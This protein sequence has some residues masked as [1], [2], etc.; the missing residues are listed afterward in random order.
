MTI[1]GFVKANSMNY[2][3]GRTGGI[4]FLVIHYTANDGDKAKS[5][6]NFFANN[7]P[8]SSAHYFVDENE[9]WQ[10]IEDK[11]TAW[12][13]GQGGMPSIVHPDCR[14]NNSIGIEMCSRKNADKTYYIKPEVVERTVHLTAMLAKKHKISLEN[15]IRHWDVTRKVCPAPFVNSAV[16]TGEM[17][18]GKAQWSAFLKRAGELISQ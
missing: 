8:K 2:Q 9:I 5:N 17:A 6:V 15:I 7:T 10:S 11:D 3:P 4:Q 16:K 12:H 14:N 13:C 18:D 1:N